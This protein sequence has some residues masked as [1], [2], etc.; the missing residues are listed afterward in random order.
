MYGLRRPKRRPCILVPRQLEY[1]AILYCTLFEFIG[2]SAVIL[3]VDR[4]P[5]GRSGAIAVSLALLLLAVV[6]DI[7]LAA[8]RPPVSVLV[9]WSPQ[10]V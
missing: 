10:L 3:E 6:A 2:G 9:G 4:S 1:T 8:A 5:G 7:V